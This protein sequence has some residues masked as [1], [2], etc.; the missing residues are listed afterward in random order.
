[1]I[2]GEIGALVLVLVLGQGPVFRGGRGKKRVEEV[3][4]RESSGRLLPDL[5]E[6]TV[7]CCNFVGICLKAFAE[8]RA[9][10]HF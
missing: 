8:S 10:S 9:W 6:L 3:E 7:I 2:A 1:M 4:S 5:R